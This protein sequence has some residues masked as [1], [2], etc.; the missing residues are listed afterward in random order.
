MQSLKEQSL[1]SLTG[2]TRFRSQSSFLEALAQ[3]G[4]LMGAF[5]YGAPPHAGLAFGLDRLCT[6]IGGKAII[7]Y[8]YSWVCSRV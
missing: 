5:E 4:F 8:L 7:F 3:F 6:I 1:A 2:A